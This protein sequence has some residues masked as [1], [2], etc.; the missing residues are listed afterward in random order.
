[1]GAAA[2]DRDPG[3]MTT[4]ALST[5]PAPARRDPSPVGRRYG[6]MWARIPRELGYLA[7]TALVGLVVGTVAWS[8]VGAGSAFIP[9]GVLLLI[10]L[11]LGSRYLGAFDL[12][13]LR[14][15][16]TRPIAEPTWQRPFAG[17]R[18]LRA[19]GDIVADGH[20]WLYALHAAV[21][22]PALAAITF[23]LWSAW[24]GTAL[25]FTTSSIWGLPNLLV[26]A[27]RIDH[28]RASGYTGD[29]RSL[30]DF[31]VWTAGLRDA[32]A[33]PIR[34]GWAVAGFTALGLLMLALL[35]FVTR[36]LTIAH[37]GAARLLLG[38]FASEDLRGE[39]A[40][41]DAARVAA[42][43]AEDTALRR[44]ERDIHD[45]PQQRLL[46]LQMELATAERRLG[47]D[48]QDAA[49]SIAAARALAA[50]TLDE[51]RALAQGFAPPLLQDRGLSAALGALGRRGAVPVETAI[52][53]E[54]ELPDAVERSV[55]FIAAEL[56]ANAI[57]H[58]GATRIRLDARTEDRTLALTVTDDGRGGATVVDG[59]GLAGVTERVAGL[60]GTLVVTSPAGGPTTVTA[61][62]PLP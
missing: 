53:I 56:T 37:W 8:V 39:V 36:G 29:S 49:G 10:A 55:Y 22:S 46:R 60:G 51:L 57:K 12:L 19:I 15:A 26:H 54:G 50:E 31:L 17:K 1:M 32:P 52:A 4:A 30:A 7:L 28:P 25:G 21:V 6:R 9:L 27:D 18:P 43:T 58:A 44:L 13:R 48:E 2:A 20:Y 33:D 59:H 35:P 23:T 5:A 3:S 11:M 41:A 24:L 61:R 34:I 14:W 47:D 38:R 16:R 40:R 42:V 45:G 62:V